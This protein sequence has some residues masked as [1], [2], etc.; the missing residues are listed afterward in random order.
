M[1][2]PSARAHSPPA[3]QPHQHTHTRTAHST[4]TKDDDHAL[5]LRRQRLH[6]RGRRQL[7]LHQRLEGQGHRRHVA[8][9]DRGQ[10]H[11][12]LPLLL[13]LLLLRGRVLVVGRLRLPLALG[14][15][16]ADSVDALHGCLV[17]WLVVAG[18]LCCV[19]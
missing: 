14:H 16:A 1:L 7:P 8:H 3:L 12:G 10:L 2:L 15:E 11:G 17:G 6:R 9:L 18:L 5:P 4:R 19:L 13:L